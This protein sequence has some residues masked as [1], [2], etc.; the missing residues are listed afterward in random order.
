MT[1]TRTISLASPPR[2]S[3]RSIP[4]RVAR[5]TS[6]ARRVSAHDHHGAVRISIHT[7]PSNPR[8]STHATR[9]ARVPSRR[10]RVRPTAS[11]SSTREP[12]VTL[13][14]HRSR[15]TASTRETVGTTGRR[16]VP[17]TGVFVCHH[18][19]LFVRSVC[20]RRPRRRVSSSW[21]SDVATRASHRARARVESAVRLARGRGRRRRGTFPRAIERR[22]SRRGT[23]RGE[24]ARVRSTERAVARRRRSGADV[25][26]TPWR[27]AR[28]LGARE[29][30]GGGK[31]LLCVRGGGGARGRASRSC[32]RG[33]GNGMGR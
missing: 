32:A 33:D 28:A 21:S 22:R 5:R 24:E 7:L 15:L 2:A 11:V 6:V 4:S 12:I 8:R 19:G 25:R 29:D 27:C 3:V 23:S 1:T 26:A 10:S 9:V 13:F 17:T 20:A 30:A 16:R 31:R 14:F 18:T